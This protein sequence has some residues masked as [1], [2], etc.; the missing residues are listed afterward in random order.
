MK[1]QKKRGC[2]RGRGGNT[3]PGKVSIP[4]PRGACNL[5]PSYEEAM[6]VDLPHSDDDEKVKKIAKNPRIGNK[7]TSGEKGKKT[8]S[9]KKSEGKEEKGEKQKGSKAQGL[10]FLN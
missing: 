8:E 1:S 9:S 6:R 2:G 7:N 10:P 4:C 3:N 5:P